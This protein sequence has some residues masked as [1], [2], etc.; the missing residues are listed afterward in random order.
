[1]SVFEVTKRLVISGFAF[2]SLVAQMCKFVFSKIGCKSFVSL[3]S[4]LF[5][6]SSSVLLFIKRSVVIHSVNCGTEF[7]P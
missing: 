2:W 1:M 7:S 4:P 5:Q 6:D 3:K